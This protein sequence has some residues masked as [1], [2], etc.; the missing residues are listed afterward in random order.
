[1]PKTI[2]KN[3]LQ[4]DECRLVQ[5]ALIAFVCGRDIKAE[6][7]KRAI[8]M[9]YA[10]R[11]IQWC[12]FFL[13]ESVFDA[14]PNDEKADL[15]TI[16]D[17][18]ANYSDCIIIILESESAYAELGAFAIQKN[19]AQKIIPINDIK[20]QNSTS[21]INLG[22]LKKIKTVG[23][24]GPV[25]HANMNSI[26]HCFSQV[27][28]RIQ[29]IKRQTKKRLYTS[30]VESF[31]SA[32]K[33]RIFL[34]HDIIALLA[35]ITRTELFD[36]FNDIYKGSRL[37]VIKFD[38]NLLTA[39]NWITNKSGYLLPTRPSRSFI[40]IQ[41]SKKI[42]IKTQTIIKYRKSDRERLTLLQQP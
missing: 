23:V 27:S 35:P 19:L 8:F 5:D 11:N 6:G 38:I 42:A 30:D 31:K 22:P 18:L 3:I 14:T 36:L 4:L 33:E 9:K 2:L 10:E 20:Y 7:S 15:L 32:N 21:F 26:S 13:A 24:L 40:D 1:M 16:E 29:R 39:L 41:I 12:N 37:D 25:I 28:E 17:H 34:I